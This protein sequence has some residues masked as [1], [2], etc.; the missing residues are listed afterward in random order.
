[1][2]RPGMHLK[3]RSKPWRRRIVVPE[4]NAG[5][6]KTAESLRTLN[7]KVRNAEAARTEGRD[8]I[9]DSQTR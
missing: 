2:R 6:E 4:K 9:G 3:G 1:M 8:R 7:I 5:P